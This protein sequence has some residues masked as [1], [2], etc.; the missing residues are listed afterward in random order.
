MSSLPLVY[1]PDVTFGDPFSLAVQPT[2][3][4]QD[5]TT[6]AA[7]SDLA[8]TVPPYTNPVLSLTTEISFPVAN[9]TTTFIVV[10]SATT[11]QVKT[12]G[13]GPIKG[14]LVISMAGYGPYTILSYTFQV[15]P[16]I[17]SH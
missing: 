11:T 15:V 5:F 4:N 17:T 14:D 16:A 9:N 13:L 10:L 7:S 6:I 1:L 2:D 12:L 8:M 3:L